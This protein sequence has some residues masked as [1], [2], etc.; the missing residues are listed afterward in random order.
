MKRIKYLLLSVLT[1]V[2]LTLISCSNS[3]NN[4]SETSIST[5]DTSKE[6]RLS[7]VEMNDIHGY[8]MQDEDGKNGFSNI[9]YLVDEIRKQV[10][11]DYVLTIANG[12]MFQGTGLVR[13]SMGEVM[14]DALNAFKLDACAL[15]NHEFD[16]DLP[17]ILKFFDGNKENGEANFPLLNGNVYQNNKLV[18]IEGGNIF[19]SYMFN[20]GDLKVG[21]IG[22]IGNVK[23]SINALFADKYTFNTSFTSLTSR[24]GGKLRDEGADVIVVS[25]HDGDTSGV[26]NFQVNQD[27]ARLRY[28]GRYLVDAIINGHTHTQQK[29]AIKRSD[30]VDLPIIQSTGYKNNHLYSFGRIDLL[31]NY[32]KE[33]I[34]QST[35]HILASTAEEI[36]NGSVE[37]VIDSY[38]K[39]DYDTLTAAY[40]LATA[41]INR[42]SSY[43]YD[44]VAD[45]MLKATGADIAICN[46]G[47]LRATISRGIVTFEDVYQMNPFDN[48]IIIHECDVADINNFIDSD[49]YF[50]GI[51]GG[52]LKESGTYKVAVIDYVYFGSYYQDCYSYT[53]SDTELILRDLIIEDLSLRSSFNVNYD[54]EAKIGLK[55]TE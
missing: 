26:E 36:Y 52:K 25:I 10:G 42:Y 53:Y 38:V 45:I 28:N 50:Y 3:N 35:S 30:G 33:V 49:Y 22:Y 48:H 20:K 47:G 27:L 51:K 39:R 19:E 17:E 14:V 34:A 18:T 13:L 24:I 16:W 15:G 1:L 29:G 2:V 8:I 5:V 12:D 31:L 6:Y 37:D 44:W 40:T 21:V 41:D 9:S 7:I 32:K 11:E 46:T 4:T 55:Y 23:S 54:Y 43:T